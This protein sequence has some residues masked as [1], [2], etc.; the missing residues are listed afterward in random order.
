MQTS[1][2]IISISIGHMSEVIHE[3]SFNSI[4]HEASV[5]RPIR[6]GSWVNIFT[7]GSTEA[8]IQSRIT[9]RHLQVGLEIAGRFVGV[10][11]NNLF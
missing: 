8:W 1:N 5:V 7:K 6:R 3:R 9:G 4:C 11:E 10:P 2:K